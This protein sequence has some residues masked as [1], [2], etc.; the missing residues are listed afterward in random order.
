MVAGACE[1]GVGVYC[2]FCWGLLVLAFGEGSLG[3][4]EIPVKKRRD[5]LIGRSYIESSGLVAFGG[6]DRSFVP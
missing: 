6:F 5:S 4:P 2:A 1:V 3:R